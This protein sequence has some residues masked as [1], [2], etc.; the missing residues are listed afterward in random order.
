MPLTF[1]AHEE[2][3]L[4]R[5]TNEKTF[6]A[7]LDQTKNGTPY[8][9][10]DGPPFATGTP[11]YGHIVGTIMKDI[12]PRYRTMRGD[13]V[14]R[15]WGWDCHG[16]PIENIIEK[17]LHLATKQDIE[18]LGVK[19][20]SEACRAAVL[21][22]VDEWKKTIPRLGRWVDMEN[23]YKTMDPEFMESVWWVFKSLWEKDLIYKGHKP[24]HICPRCATPVSNF[25]AAQGYKDIKDLS[26]TVKFRITN[27][28]EHL[29]MDGEIYALAWTTTPW[30]LPG[31]TLLAVGSDIKYSIVQSHG[32]LYITAQELRDAVFTGGEKPQDAVIRTLTGRELAGLSYEPLFPYFAD[33]QG[34]FRIVCADFVTTTDG[35]GIVH[36][37]PGFGEDDYNLGQRE[38]IP[39]VL[40]VG[41]DGTFAPAVTDFAGMNVKPVDDHTSTD[42]EIIRWLAHNGKLFSKQKYEHSY[43]HC[44]RCDTPLINYA[45]TSW[46]VKVTHLKEQ[47]IAN[48]TT[49]QWV[50]EHVGEGRFGMWLAGARDWAI[51]R[52]RYWGTPLP[53]WESEHGD[54]ICVGSIQELEELSGQKVTD[55]H[56]HI[57]DEYTIVKDG[58]TYRRIPEVLDCWFES[59]SMPYGQMHYPFENK[60]LFEK[61]FPAQFI[62]EGPDQ[63]R[64][65][66][67]TLHVLATALT[68]GSSPAIASHASHGAFEHVVVNGVVLA[69]DGKKMS[70]R[71]KNYP[72]PMVMV[73]QYG[74]DALRMYLASSP[75]M[76]LENLNFSEEGLRESYNKIINTMVNVVEFYKLF[77]HIPAAPMPSSHVLDIWIT[78]R[79][80]KLITEVTE[81]LDAYDI[82]SAANLFYDFIADLSTWYVRRSRERVKGTDTADASCAITTLY[83]TL[84]QTALTIAPFAPFLAEFI[85]ESIGE[86]HSVHLASWPTTQPG[87][88][89]ALATMNTVREYV[90]SLMQQRALHKIPVRQ[91]LQSATV[92][93]SIPQQYQSII[94]E[95]VNVRQV[96]T[97]TNS[98]VLLDTTLTD[99]LRREGA[100]R[101]Y[102]RAI[103]DARKKMGLTIRDRAHLYYTFPPEAAPLSNDER[104]YITTSCLLTDA[105]EVPPHHEHTHQTDSQ[106]GTFM[107]TLS[108]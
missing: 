103:N 93:D 56:K 80:N 101:E 100:L 70:K 75:V 88:E 57:V 63:T 94:A 46:F 95:E 43:P 104:A 83:T 51:S 55:L 42:V 98:S 91:P 58:K 106:I 32:H 3:I 1:P 78:A 22:Y 45:T 108:L 99:E 64:G 60:E 29:G 12:I 37:A 73:N 79:T 17:E 25:E 34:A 74:A 16:L 19:Q 71:L 82:P 47:L 77:A 15:R 62:A 14:A 44:W 90:S 11:H 41:I 8:T 18:K 36:I 54:T 40:H 23:D 59:G 50:P 85:Y 52:N 6:Q 76:K 107:F 10:Y 28:R 92:P 89:T 5:W 53:I 35:T 66:F 105:T 48:N 69:A 20:F 9:F 84:K 102:V 87:D 31:N 72:D 61:G 49:I 26:A 68:M 86:A 96:L 38:H 24:M 97:H 13:Y 2:R 4:A 27:A 65:W 33:T 67:Y 30:T 39:I 81:K 7:S 21:R